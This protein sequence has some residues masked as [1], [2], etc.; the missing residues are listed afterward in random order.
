M[1]VAAQ[2]AKTTTW[3]RPAFRFLLGSEAVTLSGSAVSAVALPALAVLELHASTTEVAVLAFLG[4]LPNAVALWAGALSDRHPKR[5]QLIASDLTAAGALVTVPVAALAGA[6]TVGQ[7]CAVAI[8][9]GAAK[10][11]HDAAA[12]S[13]LPAVVDPEQLHDANAKL[14]AAS[15]VADSIGTNA[16]AALVGAVGAARS[17]LVD[18]VSFLVSAVLVWRMRVPETATA[19]DAARPSLARD[20]AEGVRYVARQP[21]IRTVI[22][23]LSTLSFGLAIMNTYWAFYLLDR[24]GASPSAFGVIMGIGGA[25]GVAGALLAPKIAARIGIGPTIIAGFAVSPLAQVPLLLAEPGLRWQIVLA[26][27]LAGQ[28]FWATASGTSQRSLRQAV[29]DP[30]FQGRMQSASTTLTAG[31][32]PLAAATAG[33]LV[34]LLDVRATL[35]IGALL[36]VVPIVLLVASPIRTLRRIPAR[37]SV[38]PARE[39]APS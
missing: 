34:L 26:A 27:A 30:D 32:R 20:I 29:C 37:V 39:G 16:G 21:T 2:N 11:V 15:S 14:G 33:G 7:L 31:A 6:L 1:T 13:L 24:L 4:Q 28:L 9:L 38:P 5:P 17:V 35:A 3:S 18:A 8:V 12:I 19:P 10:V 23:A 36:Q 25:G 22:A